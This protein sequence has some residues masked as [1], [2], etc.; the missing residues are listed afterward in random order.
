MRS[1]CS[2]GYHVEVTQRLSTEVCVC[3][4][5]HN[6]VTLT[7]RLDQDTAEAVM[8]LSFHMSKVLLLGL[9]GS[10]HLQLQR[11]RVRQRVF[12]FLTKVTHSFIT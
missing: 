11:E 10:A 4:F 5:P 8:F 12:F 7:V 9:S 1:K 3:V 6:D 2:V